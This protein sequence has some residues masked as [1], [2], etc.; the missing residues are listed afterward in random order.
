M[1]MP[2]LNAQF[3]ST[4]LPF[5]T[6]PASVES[7]SVGRVST[8][9]FGGV[10]S[11][12]ANPSLPALEAFDVTARG[13]LY[14]PAA[15]WLPGFG[16]KMTFSSQGMQ[17]GLPLGDDPTSGWAAGFA[18]NHVLLDLGDFTRTLSD[19]NPTSTFHGWESAH[20]ISGGLAYSGAVSVSAGL[21]FTYVRSNL[22]PF[23]T[24]IESVYGTAKVSTWTMGSTLF[25][26]VTRLLGLESSVAGVVPFAG[27]TTALVVSD[28]GGSIHYGDQP[29]SDPLPRALTLGLSVSAGLRTEIEGANVCVVHVELMREAQDLLV[30]SSPNNGWMY[31][32]GLGDL[33]PFSDLFDQSGNEIV[34]HRRGLRISFL[35]SVTIAEGFFADGGYPGIHTSGLGISSRTLF[36]IL[37]PMM[38]DDGAIAWMLD[39]LSLAYYH[40]SYDASSGHPLD[41]SSFQSFTITFHADRSHASL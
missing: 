37:R 24:T 31:Q 7:H 5:L 19:P 28:L 18:Y 11:A 30:Q 17:Y 6:I 33:D 10:L 14:V 4:G 3:T 34:E 16:L 21:A 35:E 20:S 2:R 26:P 15:D 22:A 39:H 36:R 13:S 41:D 23:G 9:P 40:A 1:S 27:L 8:L 12:R 38:D 32:S 25:V 29:I